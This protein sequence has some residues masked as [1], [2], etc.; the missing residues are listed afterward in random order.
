MDSKSETKHYLFFIERLF[1][2]PATAS[3]FERDKKCKREYSAIRPLILV[4]GHPADTELSRAG[5]AFCLPV[6]TRCRSSATLSYESAF[7]RL[8]YTRRCLAKAIPS[9]CRSRIRA[10]SN[11]AKASLTDS[12]RFAAGESSPVN[13]RFS[14]TNSIR[15]PRL[16]RFC[17]RRRRSSRLRARRSMPCT[18]TVSFKR[19]FQQ[20]S[21]VDFSETEVER[22][23][24]KYH[25]FFLLNGFSP[26]DLSFPF[27][28]TCL[29]SV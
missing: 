15:T 14:F 13:V 3:P 24:A 16:V 2:H 22:T 8:R 10:C 5:F 12:M 26:S 4:W 6:A 23:R 11:S 17:T 20:I 18:T 21:K 27:G 25:P 1:P 9:R 7:L 28:L 29:Y 19:E